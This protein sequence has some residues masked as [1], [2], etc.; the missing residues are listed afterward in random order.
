MKLIPEKGKLTAS[1]QNEEW[2]VL[3]KPTKENQRHHHLFLLLYINIYI[4]IFLLL[5][6]ILI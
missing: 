2:E 4:C 3:G 1:E 6:K 5:N